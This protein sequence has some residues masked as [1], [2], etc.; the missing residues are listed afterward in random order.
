M[1]KLTAKQKAARK[2]AATRRRNKGKGSRGHSAPKHSLG[3]EG[4]AV[5]TLFKI[6]TDKVTTG[7]SPIQALKAVNP[8]DVKLMDM[9]TRAGTNA[10]AWDNAKYALA[11]MALH[12]AKNKPIVSILLRP[13][14]KLVKTFAGK[15]YGL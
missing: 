6:A 13:A 15:R 1:A 10:L 7:A 5:I 3:I 2:A 8:I 12:W 14:D 11:G 4:G 9:A